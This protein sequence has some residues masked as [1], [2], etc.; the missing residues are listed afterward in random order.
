M[1]REG[2]GRVGIWGWFCGRL[3]I[4]HNVAHHNKTSKG[5]HDGGGFDLDVTLLAQAEVLLAKTE[6][7]VESL[8]L[9]LEGLQARRLPALRDDLL[10]LP[11]LMALGVR[12]RLSDTEFL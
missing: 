4:Q 12:C 8:K 9:Q 6:L 2:N 1:P 7:A 10:L 5:A 3:V 11:A